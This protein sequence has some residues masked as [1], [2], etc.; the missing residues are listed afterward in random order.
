MNFDAATLARAWLSVAQASGKDEEVPI[1]D[2]TVAI[3]EFD[4]GVRLVATD[5]SALLHCWVPGLD[6]PEADAPGLADAPLRTVVATDPHGRAKGLL[7]W[8]LSEATRKDAPPIIVDLTLAVVEPD[9]LES[10]AATFIGMDREWVVLDYPN[11]ERLRLAAIE[12]K[13][14]AWRTIDATFAPVST[15]SVALNPEIVQRL[16]KLG[17]YHANA[18]LVWHFGGN[19]KVARV[20]VASGLGPGGGLEVHGFVMPVRLNALSEVSAA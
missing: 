19:D 16:A 2:R 12:G 3:E 15:R 14:P 5:R 8:L 4:A 10:D 9:D 11:H 6:D 20:S 1:L 7:S 17:K 13:Y 18:P